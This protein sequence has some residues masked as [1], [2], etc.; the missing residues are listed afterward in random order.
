MYPGRTDSVV[1]GA[2]ETPPQPARPG[3]RLTNSTL[4]VGPATLLEG[5]QIAGGGFGGAYSVLGTQPSVVEVDPRAVIRSVPFPPPTV[6][7]LHST[8]HDWIVADED[9]HVAIAGPIGGFALLALGALTSPTPTPFGTLHLDPTTM[10]AV[11]LAY[12]S[13]PAGSVQWT[14]HCPSLVQNGFPFVFQSLTIASDGTLGVT[15]PS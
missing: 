12:L 13:P 15:V 7:S 4:R 14:F 6:V 2:F 1:R 11:S 9:Y 3:A 8:Y 10:Q 5:G